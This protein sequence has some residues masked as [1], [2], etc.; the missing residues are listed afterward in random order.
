MK[1]MWISIEIVS[2]PFAHDTTNCCS[3]SVH[4]K[5]KTTRNWKGDGED[6][7]DVATETKKITKFQKRLLSY[8]SCEATL[9]NT[10]WSW[11]EEG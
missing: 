6:D 10:I 3:S 5:N 7:E 4:R 9:G 8:Q 11:I 1:K 2:D